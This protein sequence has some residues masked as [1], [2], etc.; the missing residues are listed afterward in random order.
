[1][2][3]IFKPN[4]QLFI[5]FLIINAAGYKYENNPL[6]QHHLRREMVNV[7][8]NF[9]KDDA[10]QIKLLTLIK[11]LPCSSDEYIRLVNLLFKAQDNDPFYNLT[12]TKLIKKRIYCQYQKTRKIKYYKNIIQT[13]LSNCKKLS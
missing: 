13:I 10:K 6:G 8:S 3:I 1:M 7:F 9:I 4:I 11:N 5:A 12:K 2:K